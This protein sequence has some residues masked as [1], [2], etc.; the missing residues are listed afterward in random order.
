MIVIEIIE[1]VSVSAKALKGIF[2]SIKSPFSTVELSIITSGSVKI[3]SLPEV[4]EMGIPKLS[5]FSLAAKSSIESSLFATN[6][7]VTS[8]GPGCT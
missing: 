1:A 5:P 3:K 4:I 2:W 7:P 8:Y 6:V